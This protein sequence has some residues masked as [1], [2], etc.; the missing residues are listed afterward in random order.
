MTDT[1]PRGPRRLD[2]PCWTIVTHDGRPAGFEES[3][4]HYLTHQ[5]ADAERAGFQPEGEP[6][7]K[8]IQVPDGFC[9]WV[10]YLHCGKQFVYRGPDDDAIH[11]ADET[12]LLDSMM[13]SD[14]PAVDGAA[15]VFAC[16]EPDCAL[17]APYQLAA[18]TG[19]AADQLTELADLV[20]KFGQ[21]ERLT[22]HPDRKTFESDTTHTVMLTV[23]ACSLAARFY[24]HL[25]V[26]LIAQRATVH[27]LV[28]VYA[29]DTNTL[30][31]LTDA[32]RADKDARERDALNRIHFEFGRMFPWM[33]HSIARYEQ[34]ETPEDRFVKAVDKLMPK[35]THLLNGAHVIRETGMEH[36][37]AARYEQQRTEIAAYAGEFPQL[38]DL[39]RALADRIVSMVGA[40]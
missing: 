10:A 32:Q 35:F 21:T 25:D 34:Q 6:P 18:L 13:M 31:A 12:N 37:L 11:F 39:H 24:P 9:C 40:R 19:H 1:M 23:M 5:E 4:P 14:L 16:D 36:E 28:E 29:G 22:M 26:G 30:R 20:L 2:S 33:S 15:G 3:E 7:V 8:V 27:D 17:C 38:L